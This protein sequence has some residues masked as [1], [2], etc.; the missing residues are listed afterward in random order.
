MHA[1]HQSER[2]HA[3][4]ACTKREAGAMDK[5]LLGLGSQRAFEGEQDTSL[6]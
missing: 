4:A 3:A 2:R 6:S 5:R 1:G